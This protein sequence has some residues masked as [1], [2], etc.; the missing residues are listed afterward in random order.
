MARM[1]VLV[2]IST[3]LPESESEL[4]RELLSELLPQLVL[5]QQ[6]VLLLVQA[7]SSGA[8]VCCR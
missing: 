1:L 7:W 4:V 8:L 6:Q 2:L 3:F 5:A